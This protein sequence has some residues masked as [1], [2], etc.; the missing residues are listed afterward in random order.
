MAQVTVYSNPECTSC[1]GAKSLLSNKGIAF[2]EVNVMENPA[3]QEEITRVLGGEL[4]L[5]QVV[6]DGRLVGSFDRLKALDEAGKLDQLLASKHACCRGLPADECN[7]MHRG[8]G[9]KKDAAHKGED[10]KEHVHTH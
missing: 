9:N 1:A 4:V 3:L 6:I 5:P 7:D 8:M 2:E 10:E